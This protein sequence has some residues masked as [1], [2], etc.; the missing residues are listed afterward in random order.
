[1]G[2]QPPWIIFLIPASSLQQIWSPAAQSGAWSPP[3]LGA[4]FL[5]R[6]LSPTDWLPVVTRVIW[7]FD[8]HF[9]LVGVTNCTHSTRPWSRLYPD[10]PRPDAPVIYTD[11]FLILTAW[12]GSICYIPTV[13]FNS[14]IFINYL[15]SK[16]A[17]PKYCL[18]HLNITMPHRWGMRLALG[19]TALDIYIYP[20]DI[21]IYPLDIY[22]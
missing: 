13:I 17:P 21:H 10:I 4:G 12:L 8:I 6:I 19:I 15:I 16:Q 1:M 3:L 22:I 9:F 5:Y 2:A 7:L 11:A 18:P 20:L 14:Y